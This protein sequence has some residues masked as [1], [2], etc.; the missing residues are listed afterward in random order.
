[1]TN[2]EEFKT[3]QLSANTQEYQDIAMAVMSTAEKTVVQIVKVRKN[4]HL[5]SCKL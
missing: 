2:D 5:I 3:I 4:V 1:M